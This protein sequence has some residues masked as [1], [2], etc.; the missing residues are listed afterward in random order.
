MT[1]FNML[2]FNRKPAT[3]N[4]ERLRNEIVLIIHFQFNILGSGATSLFDVGR[5]A[6]DVGRSFSYKVRMD[7]FPQIVITFFGCMPRRPVSVWF[8]QIRCFQG[9]AHLRF[10]TYVVSCQ[11]LS[12]C[13]STR[14]GRLEALLS[15]LFVNKKTTSPYPRIANTYKRK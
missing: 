15:C 11:G 5:W 9:F 2:F 8:R 4:R 7:P 14:C 10:S 13:P 12:F 3:A 6:F 1:S